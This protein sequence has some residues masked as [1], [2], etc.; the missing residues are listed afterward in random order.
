MALAFKDG[1]QSIAQECD[2]RGL[3]SMPDNA[4]D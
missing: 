3:I 1:N 4:A 2:G